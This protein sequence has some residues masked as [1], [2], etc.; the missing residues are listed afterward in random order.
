L[1][2]FFYWLNR[3][4][5]W[6]RGGPRLRAIWR[7]QVA[8]RRAIL[9]V[10]P[11]P[12]RVLDVGESARLTSDLAR[13]F[14]EPAVL[15]LSPHASLL[16]IKR[17][18]L[19]AGLWGMAFASPLLVRSS[20]EAMPLAPGAVDVACSVGPLRP[21]ALAEVRRVLGGSGCLVFAMPVV[22]S[23]TVERAKAELRAAG[24][25]VVAIVRVRPDYL[26]FTARP[27]PR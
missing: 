19:R 7:T 21:R 4:R 26:V 23:V 13:R 18:E 3:L 20:L 1:D 24:L 8:V 12:R 14:S 16:E 11:A 9:R 15:S 22:T 25:E 10:R 27:V 17:L 2:R 5:W 6:W